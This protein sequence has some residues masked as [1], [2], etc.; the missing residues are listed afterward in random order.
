MDSKSVINNHRIDLFHQEN[1]SPTSR[2]IGPHFRLCTLH[3]TNGLMCHRFSLYEFYGSCR[4]VE[5]R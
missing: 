3:G 2:E 5:L 4:F 1:P